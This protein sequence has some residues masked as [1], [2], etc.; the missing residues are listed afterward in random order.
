MR[1]TRIEGVYREY[2]TR[3][4]GFLRLRLGSDAE[5]RDAAQE[6]FIR[7]WRQEARLQDDNLPALLFVAAR[8]VAIDFLRGKQRS[9]SAGIERE[10]DGHTQSIDDDAPNQER[11][12]SAKSDLALIKRILDELPEKCRF[13][14]VSYQFD[15]QSYQDIANQMGVSQSMVRKYVQRA[16]AHCATRFDELEGWE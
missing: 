12:L 6:T 8:N 13:A 5:A 9:Q 2:E 3:L 14:F 16:I 10:G 15:E 11:T 4:I 1:R 7:L